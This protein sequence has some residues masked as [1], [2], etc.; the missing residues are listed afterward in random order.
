MRLVKC[1][2]QFPSMGLV[3]A[4]L[5]LWDYPKKEKAILNEL[6]VFHLFLLC[7]YVCIYDKLMAL[8]MIKLVDFASADVCISQ[9]HS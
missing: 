2:K 7:V 8:E 1:F 4:R 9:S 5:S 3:D 6:S